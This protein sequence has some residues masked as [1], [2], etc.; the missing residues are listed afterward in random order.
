MHLGAT[1]KQ[2]KKHLHISY[3]SVGMKLQT[4]KKS[5]CDATQT[6]HYNVGML[7]PLSY[8]HST[9][10]C[11]LMHI[12][13]SV[14]HCVCCA[15]TLNSFQSLLAILIQPLIAWHITYSLS[16]FVT[17][18][19]RVHIEIIQR[20][21]F[22]RWKEQKYSIDSRIIAADGVLTSIVLGVSMQNTL[23]LE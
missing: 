14:C 9:Q 1:K 23:Q 18:V 11:T 19:A 13:P 6:Q 16:L 7:A 8:K 21:V 15:E 3:F 20:R 10:T 22:Y 17:Y 2:T 4:Q 5:R 12:V